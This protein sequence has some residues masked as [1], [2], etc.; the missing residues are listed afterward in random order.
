LRRLV[1]NQKRYGVGEKLDFDRS[2]LV[3]ITGKIP[4]PEAKQ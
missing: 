3:S 4:T 2:K 1:A